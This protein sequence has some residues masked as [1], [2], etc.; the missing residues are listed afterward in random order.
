MKDTKESNAILAC[1]HFQQQV[2][3]FN[4]H[5]KFIIID[6]LVHTS[7]SKAILRER[8]IQREKF[9]IQKLKKKLRTD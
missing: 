6:K 2:Q 7:S 3:N 1:R 8:L 9:W 4:Y 5:A